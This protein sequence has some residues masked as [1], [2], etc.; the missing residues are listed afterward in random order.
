MALHENDKN[1]VEYLTSLLPDAD[2]ISA[3]VIREKIR[4]LEEGKDLNDPTGANLPAKRVISAEEQDEFEKCS[5]ALE[6]S[7]V[8]IRNLRCL[9]RLSYDRFGLRFDTELSLELALQR[10]LDAIEAPEVRKRADAAAEEAKEIVEG[11]VDP[12]NP[13]PK[14][15]KLAAKT[16]PGAAE[17]EKKKVFDPQTANKPALLK[18][19]AKRGWK[20]DVTSTAESLRA[21]VIEKMGEAK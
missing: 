3:K 1:N 10:L 8:L 13:L 9:L 7:R 12:L 18:Y 15:R 21:M 11:F 16:A 2:P 5:A 6:R 17:A 4:L 14:A 20:P 19:A